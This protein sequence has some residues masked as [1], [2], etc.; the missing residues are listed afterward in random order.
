MILVTGGLGYIGSQT[1]IALIEKGYKVLIVD[2]LSNSS[3]SVLERIK[4]IT[5]E[6]PLFEQIYLKDKKRVEAL[7]LSYPSIKGIIH[8]A[9]SKVVGE[10]VSKPLKYY[11]NN[12]DPLLNIL[13]QIDFPINLNNSSLYYFRKRYF[14]IP[15]LTR[16]S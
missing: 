10:S 3:L 1:V 13:S 15:F 16:F 11:R 7:F 4:Q 14:Q 6:Q 8:F 12:I 2:D 5:S 9:A